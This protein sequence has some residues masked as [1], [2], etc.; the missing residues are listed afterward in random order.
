MCKDK[1][2]KFFDSR[3]AKDYEPENADANGAYHIGIKGLMVLEKI[4][5]KKGSE[6]AIT[7]D[8]YINYVIDKNK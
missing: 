3:Y 1:D 2:G 4:R 6:L 8:E 7:R 5:N